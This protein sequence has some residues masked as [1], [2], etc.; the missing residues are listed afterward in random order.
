MKLTVNLITPR[1]LDKA[2]LRKIR[3][4]L[5]MLIGFWLFVNLVSMTASWRRHQEV[6][7]SL[8]DMTA[9]KRGS[10]GWRR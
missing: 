3:T 1:P 7:A 6:L 9:K 4:V 8:A 10:R 5:M 2:V